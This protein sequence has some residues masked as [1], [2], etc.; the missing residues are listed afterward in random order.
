VQFN[1]CCDDGIQKSGYDES[2]SP[3]A[4]GVIGNCPYARHAPI[5]NTI[6]SNTEQILPYTLAGN[7]IYSVI[8]VPGYIDLPT[9]FKC[10]RQIIRYT[11]PIDNG[12]CM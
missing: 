2:Q 3:V 4:A 9:D 6:I 12:I 5:V 7:S 10:I 11:S 8:S 1:S